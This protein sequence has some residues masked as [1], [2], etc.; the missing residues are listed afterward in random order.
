M[1]GDLYPSPFQVIVLD[2][3]LLINYDISE[4]WNQFKFFNA[5]QVTL[6]R[7]ARLNAAL[8]FYHFML[9]TREVAVLITYYCC[10]HN[11]SPTAF[12]IIFTDSPS[13]VFRFE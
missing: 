3:D 12:N 11:I 5:N 13:P 1:A 6:F 9:S 10:A 2:G 4:L 7:T 8:F